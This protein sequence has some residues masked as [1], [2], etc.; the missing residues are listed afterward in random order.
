MYT[1]I[2]GVYTI[3]KGLFNRVSAYCDMN[4]TDGGW[5]VIQRNRVKSTLNLNRNYT[6]YKKALETLMVTSGMA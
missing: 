3:R 2:S 6:E 4:T 5:I 1:S